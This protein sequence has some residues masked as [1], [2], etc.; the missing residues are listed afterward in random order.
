MSSRGIILSARSQ[1]QKTMYHMILFVWSLRTDKTNW[2]WKA[3]ENCI[4][5]GKRR[6]MREFSGLM[7]SSGWWLDMYV[8]M[9]K[10]CSITRLRFCTLYHIYIIPQLKGN[11]E[12]FSELVAYYFFFFFFTAV[13]A[14]YRSSQARGWIT[15]AAY[16]TATR[17]MSCTYDL[18]CTLWQCWILNPL[19]RGQGLNPP[20]DR[21]NVDFLTCCTTTETPV[22]YYFLR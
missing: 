2:Q 4:V 11:K 9:L 21:D 6:V 10:S 18:H 16:T 17:D 7:S 15:A 19:I 13:P 3:S 20:P 8:H 22:T 14:G 5:L 1:T 12:G